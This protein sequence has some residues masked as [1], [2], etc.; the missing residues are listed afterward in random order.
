MEKF[1]EAQQ[2]DTIGHLKY[3]LPYGEDNQKSASQSS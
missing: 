1:L 3:C 2:M